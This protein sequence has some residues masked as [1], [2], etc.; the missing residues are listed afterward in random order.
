MLVELNHKLIFGLNHTSMHNAE[1]D[2]VSFV[3]SDRQ[4]TVVESTLIQLQISCLTYIQECGDFCE[5]FVIELERGDADN[6]GL[7]YTVNKKR[8]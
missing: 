6:L 3:F 4:Q 1:T 5:D 8:E 2:M 7:K